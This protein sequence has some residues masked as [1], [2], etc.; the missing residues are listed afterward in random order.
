MDDTARPQGTPNPGS[1]TPIGQATPVPSRGPHPLSPL[2]PTAAGWNPGHDFG[3]G[4]DALP[5]LTLQVQD[6]ANDKL[7]LAAPRLQVDG[8]MVPSLGGIPLL[9]KLGQGGMGAVYYGVHPRL[10][11]EVAV[12]VLPFLLAEQ[13]P[14]LIQ[15][16]FREARIAARVQSPHLVGVLDVNEENGLFFLVMEFVHGESARKYIQRVQELGK[17]GAEEAVA[18]ELCAAAAQGLAA[19]HAEGI[20]HRDIKPDNVLVP[21]NREASALVFNAAKVSD[22]G[23]AR[24]EEMH[25]SLT[26]TASAMGTPGYMAPEQAMDAHSAGVQADVFSLGAT[27]YALLAGRAP[28]TGTS[29]TK[30]IFD[31]VQSPHPP[32]QQFRRDLHPGTIELIERCLKKNPLER[33]PDGAALL[34]ALRA[35]REAV[36]E[37]GPTMLGPGASGRLPPSAPATPATPMHFTPA[38][39]AAVPPAPQS[40][41][42]PASSASPAPAAATG[43]Q[44][45][46]F[47]SPAV[48]APPSQVPSSRPRGTWPIAAAVVLALAAGGTGVWFY[49][50]HQEREARRLEREAALAEALKAARAKYAAPELMSKALEGVNRTL[51]RYEQDSEAEL[52]ELRGAQARL[53]A[54]LAQMELSHELTKITEQARDPLDASGV[55][56][57]LVRVTALHEKHKA[58]HGL[59]LTQLLGLK[60]ALTLRAY[61][62]VQREKIF[63]TALEEARQLAETQPEAALERLKLA[64]Q[65]GKADN[66]RQFPDLLA[67]VQPTLDA[68]RQQAQAALA[69][70]HEKKKNEVEATRVQEIRK[71]FER[72][73]AMA[74]KAYLEQNFLHAENTLRQALDALGTLDHLDKKT[75][76]DLLL[77]IEAQRGRREKYETLMKEAAAAALD[78]R[79]GEA[80]AAYRKAQELWPEAPQQERVAKG[81]REAEAALAK[82]SQE[83]ALEAAR[84]LMK[85]RKWAEAAQAFTRI[86][87]Q[88]P[89]HA[90]ATRGLSD[91]L[92]ESAVE[93]GAEYLAARRWVTAEQSFARAL[94]ERPNDPA[95]RKGAA[96]ARYGAALQ[97]GQEAARAQDWF[98]ARAAFEQALKERPGDREA[99][100]SLLDATKGMARKLYA[101]AVTEGRRL[102]ASGNR[103]AA[104]EAFRRALQH[105]PADRDA[106]EGLSASEGIKATL[107]ARSDWK[108]TGVRVKKG[109]RVKVSASGEWKAYA[110]GKQV[111]ASGKGGSPV[112]RML[113]RDAEGHEFFS[114]T[115]IGRVMGAAP[116]PPKRGLLLAPPP[117]AGPPPFYLGREMIFTADADGT[118]QVRMN[119]ENA[120]V[121]NPLA[122]NE[123]HLEV[124]IYVLPAG[125][126]DAPVQPM[127]EAPQ[128]AGPAPAAVPA[129]GFGAFETLGTFGVYANRTAQG[130]PLDKHGKVVPIRTDLDKDQYEEALNEVRGY[131]KIEKGT[132]VRLQF[133]GTWYSG[134]GGSWVGP[135][136]LQKDGTPTLKQFRAFRGPNADYNIAMLVAYVS[137]KDKPATEDFNR[138]A[139]AGLS[140]GCLNKDQPLEFT[141]PETGILRMQQNR[142]GYYDVTKGAVAVTISI[143]K[144]R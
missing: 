23:L 37:P 58:T 131:L 71:K 137:E 10:Q 98:K 48:P 18:L 74:Q 32:L 64:E 47:P 53:A 63:R 120:M 34:A 113:N 7:L 5:R 122:D 108:D 46:A 19:A 51:K 72:D 15:R 144:P 17:V 60:T 88:Q 67:A 89:Q 85:N 106:Q 110:L 6:L 77:S 62:A 41:A 56:V 9:A 81:L 127:P 61:A 31:T 107:D 124:M 50:Q 22:L 83:Q 82:L 136:G 79:H 125:L 11:K 66:A 35:C 28:F 118:L 73:H 128:P 105:Q 134:P 24:S 45:Q 25:Q 55:E 143:A 69:R 78:N 102:L 117:P 3:S 116:P 1:P 70:Q 92:Y 119:E 44:P 38:P 112:G 133:S 12:K 132:R 43:S 57:A 76:Q 26:G 111:D 8:R 4:T 99:Q 68:A 14:D 97:E 95:A 16:F 21:W 49:M 59:D 40:G 54:A 27:L 13:Q 130:V 80:A 103:A 90:E 126:A 100:T 104:A 135:D 123:G 84:T 94:K 39:L 115:L 101:E 121:A 91:A 142:D 42:A 96:D 86:L 114:E 93:E 139:Q 20:V 129:A 140:W 75:A 141:M 87:Q 36:G 30:V 109:D 52:D 138:I 2:P 29:V 65:T 33:Y